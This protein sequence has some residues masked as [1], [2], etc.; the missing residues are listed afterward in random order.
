[1]N[2]FFQNVQ[3]HG[4]SNFDYFYLEEKEQLETTAYMN[5]STS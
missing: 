5:A 4:F 2:I 3:N 1:M